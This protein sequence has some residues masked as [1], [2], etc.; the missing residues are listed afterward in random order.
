M[1]DRLL[2]IKEV[3]ELLGI[4]RSFFHK[5]RTLGLFPNEIMVSKKNPRWKESEVRRWLETRRDQKGYE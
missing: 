5:L 2:R 3:Y 1:S 4:S